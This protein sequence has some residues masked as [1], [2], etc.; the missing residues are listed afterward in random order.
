MTHIYV[1]KTHI[2]VYVL[3]VTH[4]TVEVLYSG[5][6]ARVHLT[7]VKTLS[8]NRRDK[9]REIEQRDSRS[10]RH[11]DAGPHSCTGVPRRGSPVLS[12]L[13]TVPPQTPLR[14]VVSQ[15][16][17]ISALSQCRTLGSH[18]EALRLAY[19]ASGPLTDTQHVEARQDTRCGVAEQPFT[20]VVVMSPG[21]AILT[22]LTR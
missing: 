12:H 19:S 8:S 18:P 5:V 20:P 10:C 3:C 21:V 1:L 14:R 2:S 6:L 22:V 9:D 16:E 7:R 15:S 17:T 13:A 4:I 11:P